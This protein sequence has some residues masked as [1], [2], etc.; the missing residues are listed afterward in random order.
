MT[1][2]KLNKLNLIILILSIILITIL[3]IIIINIITKPKLTKEEKLLQE[4]LEILN[5]VD[6]KINYFNYN[7]IDRYIEYKKKNKKLSNKKIVLYVNINLDKEPYKDAKETTYLY[8]NYILLNKYNLVSK[9]YKPKNLVQVSTEYAKE[10]ILLTEETKNQFILMAEAAKK[11]N[12]TLYAISGYRDYTYQENL[13][14][15][16]YSIDGN[17]ANEYSSKPGHSEHHTGLA[18]DISNKTTSYEEFDKTEEFKWMQENAHKYGFI[19]R[20]PEDK[21]NETL[22]QYEPWHYRYV[23]IKIST[24]IK[25]HNISFEEYY[26]K[27]IEK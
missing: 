20:Y 1:K 6:Q 12:L 7:N 24:Y 14:N 10:N 17:K 11:E 2:R 13:Y 18:I 16:Y 25:K 9:S 21:T 19:L 3:S 22:Y 15:N 23:G 27:H 4:K 8:K 5:N 26:V